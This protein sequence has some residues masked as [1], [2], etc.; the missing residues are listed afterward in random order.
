VNAA[1][2]DSE[3]MDAEDKDAEEKGAEEKAAKGKDAE[4]TTTPQHLDGRQSDSADLWGMTYEV[5]RAAG[6]ADLGLNKQSFHTAG[7]ASYAGRLYSPRR[8]RASSGWLVMDS[9]NGGGLR[10]RRK[11]SCS[12]YNACQAHSCQGHRSMEFLTFE[13]CYF[14][15]GTLSSGMF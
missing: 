10:V 1:E 14:R 6:P 9:R 8:M 11:E 2:N 3:E 12:G 15:F 4:K 7:C 5:S 13:V